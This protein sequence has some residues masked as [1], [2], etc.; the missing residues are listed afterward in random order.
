MDLEQ[1]KQYLEDIQKM[2][3]TQLDFKQLEELVDNLS[4]ILDDS[5]KSLTNTTL[6]EIKKTENDDNDI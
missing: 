2:D 5:E 6:L 3:A 4:S 1:I